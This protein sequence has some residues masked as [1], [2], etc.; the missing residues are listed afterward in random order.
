MSKVEGIFGIAEY[1]L[2]VEKK[3]GMPCFPAGWGKQP[4][5]QVKL[6]QGQDHNLAIA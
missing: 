3:R 6:S 1:H 5:G 2:R 4:A